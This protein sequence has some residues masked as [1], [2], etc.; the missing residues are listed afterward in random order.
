[1]DAPL[2]FASPNLGIPLARSTYSSR[3]KHVEAAKSEPEPP[4]RGLKSP[5]PAAGT[6]AIKSPLRGLKSPN[7][8]GGGGGGGK[9]TSPNL[10]GSPGECVQFDQLTSPRDSEASP[11]PP[12]PPPEP[13]CDAAEAEPACDAAP[14]ASSRGRLRAAADGGGGAGA[15]SGLR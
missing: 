12:P 13:E 15:S 1:M 3:R 5:E 7:R 11:P 14:A 9:L 8:G 4:P 10:I 2:L 6:S